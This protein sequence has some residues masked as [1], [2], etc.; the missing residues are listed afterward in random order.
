MHRHKSEDSTKPVTQHH[1]DANQQASGPD[2]LTI[3]RHIPPSPPHRKAPSSSLPP[4]PPVLRVIL[5][6]PERPE[7][8][9]AERPYR[10]PI[11]RRGLGWD[12]WPMEFQ[13]GRSAFGRSG[14]SGWC[15][16]PDFNSG[17]RIFLWRIAFS[18]LI[19]GNNWR[20]IWEGAEESFLLSTACAAFFLVLLVLFVAWSFIHSSPSAV[21]FLSQ[22]RRRGKK[23]A[24][25]KDGQM[26]WNRRFRWSSF[27]S[28]IQNCVRDSRMTLRRQ[29]QS[30][31]RNKERKESRKQQRGTTEQKEN[32]QKTSRWRQK[33]IARP[34]PHT[35]ACVTPSCPRQA[36]R[37][38]RDA[39]SNR[40][41]TLLQRDATSPPSSRTPE[42]SQQSDTG[43]RDD[44][45]GYAHTR[46]PVGIGVV[47]T[48]P[49]W[50]A[51]A[52]RPLTFRRSC[53][54]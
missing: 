4:P 35:T 5:H 3:S 32:G 33:I 29:A 48:R 41:A 14:R 46:L 49:M 50:W 53:W 43:R 27:A 24:E 8:P 25:K 40:P 52:L 21:V 44:W 45:D 47:H 37:A 36:T 38:T 19:G 26:S 51:S 17:S 9:N 20:Q 10:N 54:V 22:R 30:S 18:D 6:Q 23:T 11:G 39:S 16:V 42:G 28:L 34:A 15:T 12:A 1:W 7:R 2:T 13:Y 31:T